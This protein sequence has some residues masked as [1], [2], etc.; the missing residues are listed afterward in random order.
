MSSD[1]LNLTTE[2]VATIP[3]AREAPALLYEPSRRRYYLWSRSRLALLLTLRRLLSGQPKEWRVRAL[4]ARCGASSCVLFATLEMHP[5]LISLSLLPSLDSRASGWRA[6][7]AELFSA[8]ALHGPW[9]SE[10]MHG[11]WRCESMHGS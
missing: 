8:T 4:A 7:A 10:S 11:S 1:L 6:N 2:A 9:R 3:L 5:H